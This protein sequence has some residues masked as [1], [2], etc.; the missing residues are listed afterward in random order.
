MS[1]PTLRCNDAHR[2][3]DERRRSDR[4]CWQSVCRGVVTINVGSGVGVGVTRPSVVETL[5]RFIEQFSYVTTDVAVM[6]DVAVTTDVAVVLFYLGC[7]L[8]T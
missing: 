2:Y 4:R 5:V 6:T 8:V 1:L 7:F 3:D